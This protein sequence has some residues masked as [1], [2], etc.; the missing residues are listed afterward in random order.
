MSNKLLEQF[1][2]FL[3]YK[4]RLSNN[5]CLSY[6]NDLKIFYNYCQNNNLDIK[7]VNE[8]IINEFLYSLS[9]EYTQLSI[10]RMTSALKKFY[11]F[12]NNEFNI[13]NNAMKHIKVKQ[14][15][16]HLPNYLNLEE[17]EQLL[18]FDCLSYND[19]LDKALISLLYSSGL[20]VS[21]L[22][23]LKVH[24]IYLNERVV[25][26]I[27]KGNKERFVPMSDN[28]CKYI[29]DYLNYS[30]AKNY[31]YKQDFLFFINNSNKKITRQMVYNHLNVRQKN[32]NI[33]KKISPHTLRHSFASSLINNGANLR[34]VQELL[35]HS[36]ISTTQIY[37]HLDQ[38]KK[39]NTYDKYHP[40]NNKK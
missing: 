2:L 9:N 19:Y 29:I 33:T 21:E 13:K 12:V 34:V 18:N 3:N 25:K 7:N 28:T 31:D 38:T 36:D 40:M 37:T 22:I 39:V 10:A 14:N 1:Y 20:R 8:Q 32:T 15:H 23:N 4:K 17:I 11:D 5:T 27:G 35:G 16:H 30:R 6:Q 24:N 26:V